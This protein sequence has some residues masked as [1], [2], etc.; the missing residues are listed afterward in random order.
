MY[1]FGSIEKERTRRQYAFGSEATEGKEQLLEDVAEVG[2]SSQISELLEFYEQLVSFDY[3]HPGL[4]REEYMSHPIR[5][6]RL[7]ISYSEE[8][9]LEY[10]KLCLAHNLFEVT[11]IDHEKL[12]GTPMQAVASEIALLTVDRARQW[13]QVYKQSYYSGFSEKQQTSTVK[14]LDKLDNLFLLEDNPNAE[15]K[16]LY[17]K[18]ISKFVLPLA[19]KYV[20]SCTELFSSLVSRNLQKLKGEGYEL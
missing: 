9:D 17:L 19:T 13:D 16:A 20:P 10:V 14:V 8:I 3:S 4:T 15:I 1:V 2:F 18:E 5:V 11:G 7:Y 6:A 12:Q